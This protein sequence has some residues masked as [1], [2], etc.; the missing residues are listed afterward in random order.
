M[1]YS[2]G[3]HRRGTGRRIR[4]LPATS[5]QEDRT[6]KIHAC[7]AVGRGECEWCEC[8]DRCPVIDATVREVK[9]TETASLFLRPD[10]VE[11]VKAILA[12]HPCHA[13]TIRGELC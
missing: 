4:R 2:P 11:R 3:N 5:Q 10:D 9:L 12:T 1:T 6:A 8:R 7:Q 13:D